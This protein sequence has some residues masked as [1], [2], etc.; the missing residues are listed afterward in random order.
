MNHEVKDE[1]VERGATN[2]EENSRRNGKRYE[3]FVST[4]LDER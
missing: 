1:E 2:A 4:Q 3:F